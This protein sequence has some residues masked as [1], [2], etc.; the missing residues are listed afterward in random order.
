MKTK[1]YLFLIILFIV[2]I[3]ALG[4]APQQQKQETP[5]VEK[6]SA[7]EI[8]QTRDDFG[9][10]YSC[11]YFPEG[12]KQ[13]CE[14]WKVGKQVQWPEDCNMMQYGPCTKLCEVEN[15][16][17]VQNSTT[18]TS[19]AVVDK[20][21][22]NAYIYIADLKN[23]RIVRINDMIG[24]GWTSFGSFGNGVNQFDQPK[25]LALDKQGRI[26]ISDQ[27]NSRIVRI[28]DITG[29]G[30]ISYA[31]PKP[32]GESSGPTGVRE[33]WGVDL[34]SKGRIYFTRPYGG[35]GRIDDM[36]GNGL[37]KFGE[38]GNG[39]NQ[40]DVT[41]VI[42]IDQEDRVYIGDSLNNR[43]VRIDDMTGKNWVALGKL[44]TGIGEFQRTSG[45]AFDSQGRIYI[46]DEDNYR[47]VRIDDMTGKGW[48]EFHGPDNNGLR[49]PNGVTV[50]KS[51]RIYI[52]DTLNNR[53]VRMDDFSG[54]G[55]IAYGSYG[56][57]PHQM[58]APK[59][60][61]IVEK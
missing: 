26:Y 54:V 9:C 27:R 28:D 32:S 18:Q 56:K 35:I 47:I 38:Q 49:L 36:P 29:K 59:A 3:F 2:M 50:T 60:I 39:V 55:W 33:L 22:D 41:K 1:Y 19:S 42:Q 25:Q 51:G 37:V 10:F 12:S 46:A 53:I 24:T 57:G 15:K 21:P 48:A 13:M 34:D 44:G 52:A 43:V 30:W 8:K 20:N 16:A 23:H 61:L 6:T 45:Y 7:P 58:E 40:F 31:E 14:D 5:S 4:C 11:S 17:K